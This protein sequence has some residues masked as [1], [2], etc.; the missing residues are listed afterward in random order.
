MVVCCSP[1]LVGHMQENVAYINMWY[2]LD[3]LMSPREKTTKAGVFVRKLK[4]L[5]PLS[6]AKRANPMCFILVCGI[7]CELTGSVH[8]RIGDSE[9]TIV[10]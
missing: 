4:Q 10:G 2:S 9:S 3:L 6:Y 1:R 5:T 7:S 8:R